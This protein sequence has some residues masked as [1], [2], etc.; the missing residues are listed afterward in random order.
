VIKVIVNGEEREIEPPETVAGLLEAY[1]LN[2]LMVVVERNGVIVPRKNYAEERVEEND[3]L[4]V[5]QMMAG[6]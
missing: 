3:R 1:R 5:V 2:P 4:E 6:G